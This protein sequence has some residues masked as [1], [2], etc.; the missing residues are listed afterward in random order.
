M[1]SALALLSG[2]LLASSSMAGEIRSGS[3]AVVTS[4]SGL[5][6]HSLS[7]ECN[8]ADVQLVICLDAQS[9]RSFAGGSLAPAGSGDGPGDGPVDRA[10]DSA[11]DGAGD[12]VGD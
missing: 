7:L 5:P 8:K 9:E 10:G 11:G 1:K 6:V 3:G 12:S 4:G 2:I